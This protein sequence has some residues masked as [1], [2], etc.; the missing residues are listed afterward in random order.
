MLKLRT[1]TTIYADR[2]G[3]NNNVI[4]NIVKINKETKEYKSIENTKRHMRLAQIYNNENEIIKLW[5][6]DNRDILGLVLRYSGN[7]L[8]YIIKQLN[9]KGINL[10]KKING[11]NVLHSICRYYS[12]KDLFDIIKYLIDYVV[13]INSVDDS[14]SWNYLH[15]ICKNYFGKDLFDIIKYLINKGISI[16]NTTRLGYT[17]LHMLCNDY[18]GDDLIYIIKYLIDEGIDINATDNNRCNCLQHLCMRYSGSDLSNVIDLILSYSNK[19][20]LYSKNIFNKSA[21][22]YLLTNSE[23]EVSEWSKVLKKHGYY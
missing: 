3:V 15:F 8:L 6:L 18:C 23:F 7:N 19:S 2:K 21:Y 12:G 10:S 22:Y 17:C 4:V 20:I 1:L 11:W 9:N 14:N 13:H 5:K 16:N